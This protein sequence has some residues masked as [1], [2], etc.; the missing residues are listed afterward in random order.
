MESSTA[1]DIFCVVLGC[2]FAFVLIDS[3][4]I[5]RNCIRSLKENSDQPDVFKLR[6][7]AAIA[8]PYCFFVGLLC[9]AT[10]IFELY[11]YLP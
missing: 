6:K 9:F 10:G 5:L 2:V 8:V 4:R 3:I 11:T 7:E 1:F